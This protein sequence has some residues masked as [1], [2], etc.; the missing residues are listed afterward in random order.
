MRAVTIVASSAVHLA[1][2][3]STDTIICN[4]LEER[5]AS[6]DVNEVDDAILAIVDQIIC[7]S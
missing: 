4:V 3:A 7:A 5:C 2:C 6:Q 1:M